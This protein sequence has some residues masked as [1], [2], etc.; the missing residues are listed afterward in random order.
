MIDPETGLVDWHVDL[1]YDDQWNEITQ[2]VNVTDRLQ[3][4]RGRS[5]YESEMPPS[6][7]DL[8]LDNTSGKYSPKNPESPLYGKLGRNQP[9]R[10]RVGDPDT[11]MRLD[12]SAAASMSTPNVGL[13]LAKDF[14][15][16]VDI[17]PETWHPEREQL[18]AAK[19][20]TSVSWAVIL[21][22]DGAVRFVAKDSSGYFL[23]ELPYSE[24]WGDR[25]A[26]R[27]HHRYE[28]AED[29]T[30]IAVADVDSLFTVG[31]GHKERYLSSPGE[32]LIVPTAEGVGIAHTDS[33]GQAFGADQFRGSFFGVRIARRS[34]GSNVLLSTFFDAEAGGQYTDSTAHVWSIG[35][36][37][38]PHETSARFHG[39]VKAWPPR[40]GQPDGS[41]AEVPIE[42]YGIRR[43]LDRTTSPLRSPM[44]RAST[45][46]GEMPRTIAYWPMEEPDGA[47]EFASGI[48]GPP[49][50]VGRIPGYHVRDI[51]F[52]AYSDFIGSEPLPEFHITSAVAQVPPAPP[53]GELR[54]FALVHPPDEGVP[55]PDGQTSGTA[56]LLSVRTTGSAAEWVIEV[57]TNGDARVLAS[58]RQGNNLLTGSW[59]SIDGSGLNGRRWLLGLWL[60]QQGSDIEW[61]RFAF[62]EGDPN[63]TTDFGT[64]TG[65]S[66]GS[67]SSVV[68]GAAGDLGGAAVGHVSVHNTNTGVIGGTLWSGFNA[69][70]PETALARISRLADEEQVPLVASGDPAE[71]EPVGVQKTGS[72]MEIFDSSTTADLGIFVDSREAP[73]MRY[74]SRRSLYNQEPVQ[75]DYVAGQVVSPFEPTDDDE[76]IRN[77]VTISRE[78][79]SSFRAVQED[80]PLSVEAPPVGVGRYEYSETLNLADDTQLPHQA[81]WRL[82]LGTLDE[83]RYP[84][85]T[86]SLNGSPEVIERLRRVDVGDRIQ[87]VNLPKWLPPDKAD[88]IVQGY[89]EESD[90]IEWWISFNCTPASSWS[91]GVADDPVYGRA[92]TSGS[93]VLYGVDAD[94]T[95]LPVLTTDGPRWVQADDLPD[96]F[97]FDVTVGGEVMTVTA[98][99]PLLSDNFVRGDAG[100]WD[101]PERGLWDTTFIWSA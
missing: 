15:V 97:P 45:S 29:L 78:D 82:H 52:A 39:E 42:A 67:A 92:D 50:L 93:E 23:I 30:Y 8:V 87:V 17:A 74:R 56:S 46:P 19:G 7:A 59:R 53:T 101:D 72:L 13:D 85:L 55:A 21:R 83:V 37:V 57:R 73:T 10:I 63:G 18:I 31:D 2:D 22:P 58:D 20:G 76:S 88:L 36:G 89:S 84:V 35:A 43:R 75:L 66:L 51:D 11:A 94:A 49:M 44:F 32:R 14:E 64:I 27:A 79:G 98:I 26:F 33:A 6:K 90:G 86:V 48:G 1:F 24:S 91:V 68:V 40:W 65:Q 61:Q 60:R 62:R 77:D 3:I 5:D 38:E 12:G 100:V 16:W 34:D 69:N 80:G 28:A 47:T 9:V 70:V 4:T 41:D 81:G 54:V 99:Q 71:T 96:Q 95:I 25:Q